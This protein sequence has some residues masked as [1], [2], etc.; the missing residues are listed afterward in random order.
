MNICATV[1]EV[2]SASKNKTHDSINKVNEFMKYIVFDCLIINQNIG[3]FI[4]IL[5]ISASQKYS[6]FESYKSKLL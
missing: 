4:A 5:Q 2:F 3:N 6:F 1:D